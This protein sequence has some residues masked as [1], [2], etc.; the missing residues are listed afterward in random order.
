MW[1]YGLCMFA[2]S[3]LCSVFSHT[4][5]KTQSP[6]LHKLVIAT[7]FLCWTVLLLHIQFL[8]GVQHSR[9]WTNH[10]LISLKLPSS[11]RV[12]AI[13]HFLILVYSYT[14]LL[15]QNTLSCGFKFMMLGSCVWQ[16]SHFLPCQISL[17]AH[18]CQLTTP[19]QRRKKPRQH[20]DKNG[21]DFER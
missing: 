16:K 12:M 4:L 17:G 20:I 5:V 15:Q 21:A 7:N 19:C 1:L 8:P 2:P 3:Y 13:T 10:P 14:W 6:K 9:L 18:F 11:C